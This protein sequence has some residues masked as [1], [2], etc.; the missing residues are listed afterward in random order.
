[1]TFAQARY[2]PG[3]YE[4][5]A[6][7]LRREGMSAK[8]DQI[9][10]AKFERRSDIPPEGTLWSERHIGW[11]LSK[12]VVGYGVYPSRAGW[13]F[14]GLVVFGFF[15]GYVSRDVGRFSIVR[16]FWFSVA[17][18]LPLVT[19]DFGKDHID[20][21][22]DVITSLYHVQKLLGFLVAT[23]LIGALTFF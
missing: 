23:Y 6:R 2:D 13:W 17:N 18:A 4:Q 19:F 14:L 9:T 22:S 12:W 7:I 11:N 5:L 3:P 21:G 20:H 8:A 10:Y 16:R 15:L 1:M